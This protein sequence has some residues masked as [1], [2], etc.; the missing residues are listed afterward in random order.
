MHKLYLLDQ[1]HIIMPSLGIAS[2]VLQNHH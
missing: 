1:K 2:C